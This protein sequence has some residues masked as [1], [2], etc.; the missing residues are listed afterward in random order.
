MHVVNGEEREIVNMLKGF[1]SSEY[2]EKMYFTLL[3]IGEDKVLKITRK[4]SVPQSKACD[5]LDSLRE[6]GFVEL[7]DAERP[8][9]HRAR[10]L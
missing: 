3:T 4:A 9:T 6:K 8:K 1:G 10:V 2:E 5:A 7:A